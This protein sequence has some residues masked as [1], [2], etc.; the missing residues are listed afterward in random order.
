MRLEMVTGSLRA[1]VVSAVLTLLSSQASGQSEAEAQARAQ[2]MDVRF[3]GLLSAGRDAVQAGRLTEARQ[4][5]EEALTLR[6]ED[7]D[8]LT[9]FGFVAFR[10]G[11]LPV[12]EKAT[13]AAIEMGEQLRE[14]H[15]PYVAGPR[16]FEQS[17]GGALYT[18]GRI[19]AKNGDAAGAAR[20][21][22]GAFAQ[23]Q[24]PAVLAELRKLD[25][26]IRQWPTTV[27][28]DGPLQLD[29]VRDDTA[30]ALRFDRVCARYFKAY[31]D[32][33]SMFRRTF[34]A[35]D[36]I[37]SPNRYRCRNL[38]ETTGSVQAPSVVSPDGRPLVVLKAEGSANQLALGVIIVLLRT[39]SG[40]FAARLL[41]GA[42]WQWDGDSVGLERIA[43][44][45]PLTLVETSLDHDATGCGP[46][47][48][49][50]RPDE[51]STGHFA[52]ILSSGAVGQ[53]LLTGPVKTFTRRRL[54][55]NSI[56]LREAEKSYPLTLLPPR[57]F[58]LGAPVLRRQKMLEAE[59]PEQGLLA[60][61]ET[62][63]LTTE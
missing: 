48:S 44:A 55:R 53:P 6:S 33:G 54:L 32:Q 16:K 26:A 17:Y 21:F 3:E 59:F 38:L 47:P 57:Q 51:R 7:R 12:A 28:L 35:F 25:P 63:A 19:L 61:T 62:F 50:P 46:N 49:C 42:H 45:G 41:D 40:W 1:L 31:A 13:R 2:Q 24:H 11:D 39:P 10:L 37:K 36:S 56:P 58:R 8:V 18:L 43:S 23:T 29:G 30:D 9:E 15:R 52:F 4:K 5:F 34:E 14:H 22:K 60:P 20:A 27:A